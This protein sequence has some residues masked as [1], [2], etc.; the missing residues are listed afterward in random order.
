MARMDGL[1]TLKE[2]R[3][4]E[5][6][7]EAEREQRGIEKPDYL[8]QKEWESIGPELKE[9]IATENMSERAVKRFVQSRMEDN[10]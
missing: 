7:Q 2:K 1:A 10:D 6:R 5:R 8:T 3:Q 4:E 9:K